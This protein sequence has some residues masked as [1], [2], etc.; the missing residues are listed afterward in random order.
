MNG[1]RILFGGSTIQLLIN[2][3]NTLFETVMN[4]LNELQIQLQTKNNGLELNDATDKLQE[5][6]RKLAN[7]KIEQ[8]KLLLSTEENRQ[9]IINSIQSI[10]TK[11]DIITPTNPGLNTTL[12][13]E[14]IKPTEINTTNYDSEIK[15]LMREME[16]IYN[17]DNTEIIKYISEIEE[18]ILILKEQHISIQLQINEIKKFNKNYEGYISNFKYNK[19]ERVLLPDYFFADE[20]IDNDII[21]YHKLSSDNDTIVDNTHEFELLKTQIQNMT[22]INSKTINISDPNLLE[23]LIGG[24]S[25]EGI[26]DNYNKYY[27]IIMNYKDEIENLK[28]L[29]NDFKN[30]CRKYNINY[31]KMYNHITFI[32]DYLKLVVYNRN[33]DYQIY[34]FI[35]QNMVFY[36]LKIINKIYEEMKENTTYGKFFIKYHYIN[37]KIIKYFLEYLIKNWQPY[38]DCNKLKVLG[39]SVDVKKV[40]SKI[41]L[42]NS[43]LLKNE[44]FK[45]GVFIFNS[46]KDLLDKFKSLSSPP[47]AVYLRINDRISSSTQYFIKNTKDLQILA[48]NSNCQNIPENNIHNIKFEQIFDSASFDD[49]S[50]LSK[51]MSIPTFLSQG[52]S[53]MLLTYGYSGVGK[54][55]TVFGSGT[56]PGMLQTSLTQIQHKKEIKF[57]VYELYGLAFPYKS[58]W[59]QPKDYYHFIYEYTFD[60]SDPKEIKSNKMQEFVNNPNNYK[61]IKDDE[62]KNF[63]TIT[64]QI[65]EVRKMKG[66]IKKTR[67]NDF[68]SRSIII[69]D[70]K[71]TLESNEKPVY[72]V[73]FDLPGKEN[74]K[75]TFIDN[76]TCFKTRESVDSSILN[77]AILSPLSLMLTDYYKPFYDKFNTYMEYTNFELTYLG[78]TH[79]KSK[80]KS[81]NEKK[82][83][84]LEINAETGNPT[85]KGI[86][87]MSLEIMRYLINNNKFEELT[88]FY[89]KNIFEPIEYTPQATQS[90]NCYNDDGYSKAPF[91]GF[92]INE[93]IIGLLTTLL[94]KLNLNYKKIE[95]QNEIFL[96]NT[97]NPEFIEYCK[98]KDGIKYNSDITDEITA[99]TYFFRFLLKHGSNNYRS[100]GIQKIEFENVFMNKKLNY[101]INNTYDFNKAYNNEEPPIA[102]LLNLYFENITNFYLFYVVSNDKPEQC[103][104]QI[105]LISDC[106]IFLEELANYKSSK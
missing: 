8:E 59:T 72:F 14:L 18:K 3:Q 44:K 92:Y 69:F 42:Y 31:V 52:K 100:D 90:V 22:T 74:I 95:S 61:V 88:E 47:V 45:K 50:V 58:Y 79:K 49:N 76:N 33:K 73:I 19:R 103:D 46:M 65:D 12:F 5:I 21:T 53:I 105:R 15:K 37:I 20:C 32:V 94:K 71:I 64:D 23:S 10:D 30:E 80:K 96:N 81:Y 41:E 85:I 104:K 106:Q 67:N 102:T 7:I 36:Y 84:I 75:D 26:Y 66:R 82:N 83:N 87:N 86:K 40:T 6:N 56:K 62:I 35:G 93:N 101:W 51:Y 43:T 89:E 1:K 11:L 27:N 68:S 57:R 48:Q 38:H 2:S 99:Q 25:S 39:I 54:T 29:N 77:L 24:T 70:F 17:R 4:D 78:T 98:T 16:S 60:Y 55:Y 28:V 91:E 34:G 13:V 9:T 97:T 63:A